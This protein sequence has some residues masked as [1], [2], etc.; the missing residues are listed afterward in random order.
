MNGC[1]L[2]VGE[3]GEHFCQNFEREWC[4]PTVNVPSKVV[5]KPTQLPLARLPVLREGE[6]FRV[7]LL[8]DGETQVCCSLDKESKVDVLWLLCAV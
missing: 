3:S 4:L 8:A 7:R 2:L 6:Q 1:G 5:A